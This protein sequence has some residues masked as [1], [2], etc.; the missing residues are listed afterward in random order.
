MTTCS[1]PARGSWQ[2]AWDPPR[3]RVPHFSVSVEALWR[4]ITSREGARPIVLQWPVRWARLQIPCRCLRLQRR[5]HPRSPPGMHR[6]QRRPHQLARTMHCRKTAGIGPESLCPT[7]GVQ[8]ALEQEQ[9]GFRGREHYAER[10]A[11]LEFSR[12]ALSKNAHCVFT[13]SRPKAGILGCRLA[14]VRTQMCDMFRAIGSSK[15]TLDATN[16]SHESCPA[17]LNRYQ[18]RGDNGRCTRNHGA[19]LSSGNAR[20]VWHAIHDLPDGSCR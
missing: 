3:S 18:R 17:D 19:T 4:N 14:A 6:R 8:V 9:P 5:T 1:G 13:L 12:F 15:E 16:T 7:V 2:P 11:S 10:S 20:S